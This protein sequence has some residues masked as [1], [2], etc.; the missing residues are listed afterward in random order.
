LFA[1]SINKTAESLHDEWVTAQLVQV[2]HQ[3]HVHVQYTAHIDLVPCVDLAGFAARK[4]CND[5]FHARQRLFA[6]K[7][8]APST[9]QSKRCDA[10]LLHFISLILKIKQIS[11]LS[12]KLTL[13]A[14]D[15]R[16]NF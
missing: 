2:R 16:G 13:R 9:K 6:S 15:S 12:I 8:I 14:F 4:C 10:T 3:K 11:A 7:Q 1:L 5:L